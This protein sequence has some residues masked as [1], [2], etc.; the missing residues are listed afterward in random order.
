MKLLQ[1]HS[2]VSFV[3]VLPGGSTANS[4]H[5]CCC[6]SSSAARHK[7]AVLSS[8]H[9]I[10]SCLLWSDTSVNNC[11]TTGWV[12]FHC[13]SVVKFTHPPRVKGTRPTF[14]KLLVFFLKD[15]P[16]NISWVLIGSWVSLE[17]PSPPTPKAYMQF[18][19]KVTLY[20]FLLAETKEIRDFIHY[21]LK[22]LDN[23][24]IKLE[25]LWLR[26]EDK[27]PGAARHR[28]SRWN[29]PAPSSSGW[30]SNKHSATWGGTPLY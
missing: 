25:E 29:P 26:W 28:V 21:S 30:F 2:D 3:A 18:I 8:N 20:L 16:K 4:F 17:H 9:W 19:Y 13:L 14:P 10:S 24:S 6:C 1:D 12:C 22:C 5:V 7:Q 15:E 27:Q 23:E 11:K